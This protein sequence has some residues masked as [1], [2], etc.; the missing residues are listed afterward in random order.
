MA[1]TQR[2][3]EW[4]DVIRENPRSYRIMGES[5]GISRETFRKYVVATNQTQVYEKAKKRVSQEKE[6]SRW[7]SERGIDISLRE[8]LSGHDLWG[9]NK[10][11][12][13]YESKTGASRDFNQLSSLLADYQNARRSNRKVSIEILGEPY[14]LDPGSVTAI[15]KF[16]ELPTLVRQIKAPTRLTLEQVDGLDRTVSFPMPDRDKSFFLGVPFYAAE[17]YY[18]LNWTREKDNSPIARIGQSYLTFRIASQVYQ[19]SHEQFTGPGILRSLRIK[20]PVRDYALDNQI[21]ISPVIKE[22]LK[23]LHNR[24]SVRHPW[25]DW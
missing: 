25:V 13:Y 5:V 17:Q 24:K 16:L 4:D 20:A 9:F 6:N 22:A 18:N 10:A 23:L 12:E 21:E 2:I 19:K 11:V 7:Y 14:G 15:L 1:K 3:Q 8:R